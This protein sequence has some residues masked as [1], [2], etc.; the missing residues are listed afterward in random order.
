MKHLEKKYLV[1]DFTDI[2]KKLAEVSATK[3][4]ESIS[5]HYYTD[6]PSN[7]V[8]KLVESANSHSIH[9][10]K[11]VNGKFQLTQNI[12]LEDRQTGLD[13]LK[14]KGY[15]RVGIVKMQH[16]DYEY[17]N[18]LVGLYTIND[19]LY[20]IILDF[21]DGE[22]DSIE[23]EFNLKDAELIDIPYNKYLEQHDNLD[24]IDINGHS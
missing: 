1:K 8:V 15:N 20:S 7:D 16:T 9:E 4:E 2:L 12:P 17:K 5:T 10:L 13:W 3:Q 19:S 14:N 11:F 21:P 22:H 24:W 6:Q 23:Q 18:G